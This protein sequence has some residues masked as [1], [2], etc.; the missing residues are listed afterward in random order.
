[1]SDQ[2]V[3]PSVLQQFVERARELYTLPAVAVEVLQLTSRPNVDVAALKACVELDPALT[4]KLLRV[5][6]SAMFGLSREVTDLN[7]AL[8]L[9]GVKPLKLL[10]LGFSLPKSLYAGVEGEMLRHYWRYTLV[11]AVAARELAQTFWQRSGDEAFIAGLLQDIGILVLLRELGDP[12]VDFLKSVRQQGADL[13][14]WETETLGFDH[15]TLSARLLDHWSLPRAIVDAVAASQPADGLSQGDDERRRLPRILHLATLMASIIVDDR[16][17]LMAEL[18]RKGAEYRQ[19]TMPQID[20]MLDRMQQ[21][22]E[23]MADVFALRIDQPQSYREILTLAHRRMA[24]VAEEL[25]PGMLD[26]REDLRPQR[27]ALHR[28]LSR[29][30]DGTHRSAPIGPTGAGPATGPAAAK[31]IAQDA[32]PGLDGLLLAAIG[33][34]HARQRELSLALL[35]ID[36]MGH[37][38][39]RYGPQA[40]ARVG[41]LLTRAVESL[42]DI[43]CQTLMVSDSRCAVVLPDCDRRQACELA[44]MLLEEIPAYLTREG[45]LSGPLPLSVGVATLTRPGRGSQPR[46]LIAAAD[47]CLF[48]ARTSGGRVVKSIDLL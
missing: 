22:V 26:R 8:A 21:R 10:V 45:A 24:E 36:D 6:N 1:M 15:A 41:G 28:A 40:M 43:D 4:G 42:V 25:L 9:L 18:L 44:R 14:E 13:A 48:A 20:A 5:V 16:H 11:K 37:W 32:D 29:F 46:D 19:I 2:A 34:C 7:Q 27:E 12:Y 17:E 30:R 38:L 39:V 23:M 33:T 35:E 47:R 3:S 31:K